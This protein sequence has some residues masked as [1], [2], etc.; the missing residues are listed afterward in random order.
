[1][2][3]GHTAAI[4]RRHLG[5]SAKVGDVSRSVK[6]AEKCPISFYHVAVLTA[7]CMIC[8]DGQIVKMV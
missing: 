8:Y 2:E 7:A 3:T 1:M 6:I 5:W 4:F